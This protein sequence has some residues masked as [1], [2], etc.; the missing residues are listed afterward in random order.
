LVIFSALIINTLT[1]WDY[2]PDKALFVLYGII[3]SAMV[4]SSFY[5]KSS[6]EIMLNYLYC[7]VGALSF[8]VSDYL[9]AYTKFTGLET[10]LNGLFIMGSY[11]TAQFMILKGNSTVK[12]IVYV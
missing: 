8:L 4:I 11:Y 9:I 6:D 12:N 1:L 10:G 5:R 7:V 3:M 2:L